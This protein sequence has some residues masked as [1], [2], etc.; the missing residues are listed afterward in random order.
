L[1]ALGV[2]RTLEQDPAFALRI[3]VDIAIKALSPAI[4]DPT[5][6]VQVLDYIETYLHRICAAN[7]RDQYIVTDSQGAPRVIVPGRSWEDHVELAV[8]EIRDYGARSIQV[9]RRL[10]ALLEGVLAVAAADRRHTLQTQLSLLDE[11]ISK[12]FDNPASQ[13]LARVSDPQGI[14]APTIETTRSFA[15]QH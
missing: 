8:T 5:T 3:L 15:P 13:A 11:S 7:L 2:E 1:I 9:C 4:N 12:N 14:G 10:R 6:A